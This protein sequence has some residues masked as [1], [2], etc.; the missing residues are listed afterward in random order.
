MLSLNSILRF[1]LICILLLSLALVV[2]S[3]NAQEESFTVENDLLSSESLMTEF[4]KDGINAWGLNSEELKEYLKVRQGNR[5]FWSPNLHPLAAL[6]M[7]EGVTP[8]ERNT[9]AEKLVHIERK[10]LQREIAFEKAF[11]KA[12]KRYYSHIP[13]FLA[14][15][16]VKKRRSE[17]SSIK[18]K[19]LNYYVDLP[20]PQ[21]KKPIQQWINED[22]EI[23]LFINSKSN[24]AIRKFAKDMGISPLLVPSKIRLNKT[25]SRALKKAGITQLPY[26]EARK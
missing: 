21:C 18:S 26:V 4:N 1:S 23:D 22:K 3:T 9:L 8:S 2:T 24:E 10:R 5:Q 12:N 15:P 17:S 19:Y 7:R 6:G 16:F 13:L 20:C 25:S 14:D 11:Q